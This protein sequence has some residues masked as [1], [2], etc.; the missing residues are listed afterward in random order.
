[1]AFRTWGCA[2][3][4]L[5]LMRSG[6]HCYVVRQTSTV[7]PLSACSAI[8]SCGAGPSG[9]VNCEVSNA[10]RETRASIRTSINSNTCSCQ[11][12]PTLAIHTLAR[13]YGISRSLYAN[14]E[15]SGIST[16]H[17]RGLRDQSRSDTY[18]HCERCG[19]C[20]LPYVPCEGYIAM[21]V[22]LQEMHG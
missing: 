7:L 1:M 4:H 18:C 9:L 16:L 15:R 14:R 3:P 20:I 19:N 10:V 6:H 21:C 8:Y 22:F 5:F 11:N 2:H 12:S 17:C 13:S